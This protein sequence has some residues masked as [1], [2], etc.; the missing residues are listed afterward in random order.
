M[1]LFDG[2]KAKLADV[3]K[4]QEKSWEDP[5]EWKLTIDENGNGSATIRLLPQPNLEE[6]PI[7][8]FYDHG[9]YFVNPIDK[10]KRW[11][12]EK[13]PVSI[14]KPCPV[15]DVYYELGA[16]G[17][18]EAKEFQSRIS[19][20]G[21]FVSN[22][23][24]VKDP[25]NPD[26]EGKVFYWIFGVKLLEKFMSKMEPDENL[27]AAGVQPVNLFDPINGANVIVIRKKVGNM[28][29]NYDDT[30]FSEPYALFKDEQEAV[31]FIKNNCHN[32]NEKFLSEKAYKSYEELKN[33]FHRTISGTRLEALLLEAGSKVITEPY[34]EPGNPNALR[35]QMVKTQEIPSA[36]AQST[37]AQPTQTAKETAMN[38]QKVEKS[39]VNTS[40]TAQKETA[41]KAVS[42]DEID[43]I[44]N[45]LGIG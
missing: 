13:S 32:L 4:K 14:G 1:G 39:A 38:T 24:V 15:S 6:S 21:R 45:E 33:K 41:T 8:K 3:A 20:R 31:E 40:T 11:Y 7:V 42:E 9:F 5:N 28:P 23:Y 22:I 2:L 18:D 25:G 12:I 27:I 34:D 29:P 35:K 19:R 17:T 16:I 44:L 43:D 37:P 26:N 10:K 30:T 36:T